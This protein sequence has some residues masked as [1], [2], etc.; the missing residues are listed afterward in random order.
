V[1]PRAGSLPIE[2]YRCS[3]LISFGLA[4]T[5][6]IHCFSYWCAPLAWASREDEATARP[7]SS[8]LIDASEQSRSGHSANVAKRAGHRKNVFIGSASHY[9][10]CRHRAH[11][12]RH[13]TSQ[14]FH[15]GAGARAV[16]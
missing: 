9:Q 14:E 3:L 16:W 6:A 12:H 11:T 4:D 1:R 5:F 10:S 15:G 8:K 7:R 2:S 13:N